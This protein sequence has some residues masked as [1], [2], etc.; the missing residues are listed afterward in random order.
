VDNFAL[1]EGQ[2]GIVPDK[3][4]FESWAFFPKRSITDKNGPGEDYL[5]KQYLQLHGVR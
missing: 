5:V 3:V 2:M 4:L 1:I